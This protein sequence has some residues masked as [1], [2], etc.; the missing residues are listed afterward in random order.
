MPSVSQSQHDLM[1]I[2]SKDP[3]FAKK[4]GIPQKVAKEFVEQ[5]ELLGLWQ[6]EEDK[7]KK[8]KKK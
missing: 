3:E 4:K 7:K 8:G 2:A 6:T 1:V 5:D